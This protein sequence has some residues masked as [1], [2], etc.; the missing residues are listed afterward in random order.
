VT[1]GGPVPVQRRQEAA[2]SQQEGA[3]VFSTKPSTGSARPMRARSIVG[4]F[5]L[6]MGGVHIGLVSADTEIYRHFADGALIPGLS[7]LWQ[8]VFM[9]HPAVWGLLL[10]AFEITCGALLL[11]GGRTAR[12]GWAGVLAFHVALMG[13]GWGFWA[14]SAP[15]LTVLVTAALIDWARLDSEAAGNQRHA[16]AIRAS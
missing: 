12:L 10:A 5:F 3:A 8:E 14:W 2:K 13:F 7:T 4:G 16:G 6:T 9:A 11:R 15:V 1:Q